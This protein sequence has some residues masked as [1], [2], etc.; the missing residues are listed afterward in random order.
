MISGS[1]G[2]IPV[3]KKRK[4]KG[5]SPLDLPNIIEQVGTYLGLKDLCACAL[6]NSHFYIYLGPFLWWLSLEN[7]GAILWHLYNSNI[8]FIAQKV[9]QK[10]SVNPLYRLEEDFLNHID[11]LVK[12]I[13]STSAIHRRTRTHL[14]STSLLSFILLGW[15]CDNV[16]SIDFRFLKQNAP[17]ESPR[18]LD[19]KL[20]PAI[21]TI[22]MDYAY[23]QERPDRIV[24]VIERSR[25]LE[26]LTLQNT[27][28]KETS[29]L[30]YRW[31]DARLPERLHRE[32]PLIAPQ[33]PHLHTVYLR[34]CNIDGDFVRILLCNSP[35]LRR[36]LLFDI[37]FHQGTKTQPS[38]LR[39]SMDTPDNIDSNQE[40][41]SD[42]HPSLREL[43]LR[44]FHTMRL[45]AN[46]D[47]ARLLPHYQKLAVAEEKG[48]NPWLSFQTGFKSLR[49]LYLVFPPLSIENP[50][51]VNITGVVIAAARLENLTIGGGICFDEILCSAI[52][53]RS[54]TLTTLAIQYDVGIMGYSSSL[55]SIL[56]SCYKLKSFKVFGLTLD[57]DPAEFDKPWA[58]T[59]L[60][61]LVV[62]PNCVAR[63]SMYTSLEA[64]RAFY[65]QIASLIHLKVLGFGGGVGCNSFY[66]A[67]ELHLLAGLEQLEILNL[68]SVRFEGNAALTVEDAQMMERCWPKLRAILGLYHMDLEPFV[69]YMESHRPEVSLAYGY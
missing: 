44:Y 67:D 46:Q 58:C 3:S 9:S 65:R 38:T 7:T 40:S 33:W 54:G 2:V 69:S 17:H 30:F 27:M 42:A 52:R 59:E 10:N 22:S 48:Y 60:E 41:G 53:E 55:Y 11:K 39:P 20:D 23:S 6:V 31:I 29:A 18:D 47:L 64:Q 16:R 32:S 56:R 51:S 14:S 63:E 26:E 35:L 61:T 34:E 12:K 21:Y 8:R 50:H 5:L 45:A 28:A 1:N 66:A 43:T 13:E 62:T 49:T 4:R 68:K 19:H 24:Q 25:C 15:F 57:C 37:D 36:L